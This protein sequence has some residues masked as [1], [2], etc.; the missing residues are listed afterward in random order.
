MKITTTVKVLR[1]FGLFNLARDIY[2]RFSQDNSKLAAFYGQFIA[3]DCLCFDIGANIGQKIDIFLALG[4]R[5]V[6]VE[7]QE[8]CVNYLLK[9]YK[10]NPRVT[11]VPKAIAERS[12][13]KVLFLCDANALSTTSQEWIAAQ[14][15]SGHF[16][17]FSW[18]KKTVVP[19]TTLADL[20]RQY[21]TPVFCKIDVE[22]GELNAIRGL[23][24][25][26][27]AIALEITEDGLDMAEEY[28]RHLK[29]LGTPS[30]NYC[31]WDSYEFM[32][33]DWVPSERILGELRSLPAAEMTG[34]LYVRLR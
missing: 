25:R 3:K 2:Y 26:I 7:P 21:G 27:P 22:G 23:G 28:I 33:R 24:Q 9:K 20:I 30:F 5:V 12:G 34:D 18:D 1:R 10:N 13:E 11:V 14:T 29:T 8:D 17:E 19:A 15:K 4:A 6:A 32:F 16:G 31:C